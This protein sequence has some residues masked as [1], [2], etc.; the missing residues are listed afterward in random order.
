MF[1]RGRLLVT[2]MDGQTLPLH[3]YDIPE[4]YEFRGYTYDLW[5]AT[6]QEWYARTEAHGVRDGYAQRMYGVGRA[7]VK[8]WTIDGEDIWCVYT[9]MA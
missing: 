1:N 9:R 5:K 4:E 6:R 7:V 3:A 8:R 2:N